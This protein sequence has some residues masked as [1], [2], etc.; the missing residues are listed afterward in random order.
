MSKTQIKRK[1][2]NLLDELPEDADDITIYYVN[3]YTQKKTLLYQSPAAIAKHKHDEQN[4][5]E[6]TDR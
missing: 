3:P 4:T 6:T 2:N 1:I 5:P